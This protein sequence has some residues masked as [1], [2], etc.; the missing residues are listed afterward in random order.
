M[1]YIVPKKFYRAN[2]RDKATTAS[3]H[4]QNFAVKFHRSD[5]EN[6]FMFIN[7]INLF[8]FSV[9]FINFKMRFCFL[10]IYHLKLSMF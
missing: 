9:L 4:G 10:S 3:V 8:C 2:F 5:L 6:F 1:L 7:C